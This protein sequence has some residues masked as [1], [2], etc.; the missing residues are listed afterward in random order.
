MSEY[1]LAILLLTFAIVMVMQ[2]KRRKGKCAPKRSDMSK[3]VRKSLPG[4]APADPRHVSVSSVDEDDEDYVTTESDLSEEEQEDPNDYCRGGYHPV[5]IG[6]LYSNRYTVVRKLG[7]GHF[8]TVWLAKDKIADR[9]VAMKVVKSAKRYTE[10]AVDEVKL[11]EKIASGDSSLLGRKNVI[12]LYDTF[13][14]Y[15]INGSHICMVFEV[16]GDTL[17]KLII[18]HKYKGLPLN[19]VKSITAQV[20]CGLHYMHTH[21]GI[22]HTDMKPENVLVTISNREIEELASREV[23][24]PSAVSTAPMGSRNKNLTLS[25]NQKKRLKKKLKKQQQQDS[26]EVKPNQKDESTKLKQLVDEAMDTTPAP[27]ATQTGDRDTLLS[28][29]D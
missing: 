17:L 14:I 5:E 18:Q 16:L 6:D 19:V 23:T 10:T 28:S 20:L 29:G 4:S 11:L 26:S 8:S 13:K 22:I 12:E 25:K 24:S 9:Y 1:Y 3:L 2:A 7:W 27:V 21:C 15:G